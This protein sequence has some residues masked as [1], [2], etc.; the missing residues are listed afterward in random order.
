MSPDFSSNHTQFISLERLVNVEQPL[1]S[2]MPFRASTMTVILNWLV[3]IDQV[4]TRW[5]QPLSGNGPGKQEQPRLGVPM[6]TVIRFVVNRP[7]H[8]LLF[9]DFL[10]DSTATRLN[11]LGSRLNQVR[12]AFFFGSEYGQLIQG[13]DHVASIRSSATVSV[14]DEVLIHATEPERVF[15]SVLNGE[16]E[17]VSRF[18]DGDPSNGH[19]YFLHFLNPFFFL[20]RK[21][22]GDQDQ[23]RSTQDS[24]AVNCRVWPSVA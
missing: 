14:L 10:H 15:F 21:G 5:I 20:N 4:F 24:N 13:I 6:E 11:Y 17:K 7:F 3:V 19:L 9:A 12:F 1:N 23:T 2:S 16:L 22:K 8:I 18:Y